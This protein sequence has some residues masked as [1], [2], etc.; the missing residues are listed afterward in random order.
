MRSIVLLSAAFALA[1]CAETNPSAATETSAQDP[2]TTISE[3]MSKPEAEPEPAGLDAILAAQPDAVQARYT[4]RNPAQTLAFFGIE[5]GMT[6][7][8]ALPGGGWYSKL[9]LPYLGEEGALIGVL[10]SSTQVDAFAGQ[11][12]VQVSS[13]LSCSSVRKLKSCCMSKE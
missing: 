3:R 4:F 1:A 2:V 12:V 11:S 10:L 5:P 9:L 6:V 13:F 8:E 7:V